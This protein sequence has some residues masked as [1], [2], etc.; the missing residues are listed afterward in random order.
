MATKAGKAALDAVAR[1]LRTNTQEEVA[2]LLDVSLATVS[3]WSRRK[4]AP[5]GGQARRVVA[6]LGAP[7]K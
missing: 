2:R 5:Q 6:A 3:R 7:R 4:C 1:A